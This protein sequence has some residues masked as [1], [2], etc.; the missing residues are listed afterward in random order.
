MLYVAGS[1]RRKKGYIRDIDLILVSND[2]TDA[3]ERMRSYFEKSNKTEYIE[4]TKA[5][6]RVNMRVYRF[7]MKGI[8]IDM[9]VCKP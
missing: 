5:L 8:S 1:I 2:P 9:Y 4:A 6:N 3:I 7:D